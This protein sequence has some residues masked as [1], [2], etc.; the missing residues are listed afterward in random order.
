MSDDSTASDETP[1]QPIPDKE[2]DSAETRTD[3]DPASKHLAQH[4]GGGRVPE[5]SAEDLEPVKIGERR[6]K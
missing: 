6:G 3:D 4:T 1:V 5:L 2:I